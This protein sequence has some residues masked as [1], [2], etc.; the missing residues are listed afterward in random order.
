GIV[1]AVIGRAHVRNSEGTRTGTRLANGAWW[2]CG[3]GG[4][5]FAA[6][7]WAN[8]VVMK[9][10][11]QRQADAFLETLKAGKE[12]EAFERYVLAPEMRGRAE[13]GSP[14]FET[15]YMPAGYGM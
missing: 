10:E 14:D 5:G 4:A 12:Q 3:L 7:L 2:G 15:A 8:F 6:F 9:K 1:L 13:P 11:S